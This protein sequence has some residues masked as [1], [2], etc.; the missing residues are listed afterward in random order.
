MGRSHILL[1]PVLALLLGGCSSFWAYGVR[2]VVEE[3]VD[4]ADTTIDYARYH[5]LAERAWDQVRK[6]GSDQ[7]YSS[8]Y[9]CGFKWGYVHYLYFGDLSKCRVVPPWCYRQPCDETPAGHRAIEDWLAAYRHGAE[10]ARDSGVHDYILLPSTG[11]TLYQYPYV[12]VEL[13]SVAP[14]AAGGMEPAHGPGEDELPGPRPL[15][16]LAPPRNLG[17]DTGPPPEPSPTPVVPRNGTGRPD[18]GHA[19][20][21][22]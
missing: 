9:A 16:P 10:V 20:S 13:P 22:P 15:D 8:D 7:H 6:A 12:P 14:G 18:A 1:L 11:A 19:P 17:P 2:N 4:C 5:L 3:P 21:G